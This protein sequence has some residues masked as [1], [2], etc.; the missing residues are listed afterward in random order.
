MRQS[1]DASILGDLKLGL[2]VLVVQQAAFL[3][4]LDWTDPEAI[5]LAE[6]RGRIIQVHRGNVEKTLGMDDNGQT[7]ANPDDPFGGDTEAL[8]RE[9]ERRLLRH[10]D[11]LGRE[12]LIRRIRARGLEPPALGLDVLGASGSERTDG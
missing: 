4:D 7:N 6:K 2:Q 1:L 10:A 3:A 11:K 5:Q 8:K 9:L 12:E